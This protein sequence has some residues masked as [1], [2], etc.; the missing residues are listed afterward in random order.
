MNLVLDD[1]ALKGANLYEEVL[2]LELAI[3]LHRDDK[4]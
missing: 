3:A 4:L 1:Q 2:R